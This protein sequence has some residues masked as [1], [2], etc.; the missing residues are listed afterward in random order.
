[1]ATAT[2]K[3]ISALR[4]TAARL[5]E[6]SNFQ[7]GHMGSC[8]C[9]HLA[10]TVTELSPAEIHRRAMERHGDWSQQS[11][12]HCPTS[13]LAIDHV[14]DEMLALGL[15]RSSAGGLN[16]RR[17][18]LLRELEL[19]VGELEADGFARANAEAMAPLR[20]QLK[21]SYAAA[22]PEVIEEARKENFFNPALPRLTL[23]EIAKEFLELAEAGLANTA[24]PG[25]GGVPVVD[26]RGLKLR[27][28][29]RQEGNK[30][31]I[32]PPEIE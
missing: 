28:Q 6:G 11:V 7:W 3:L 2:P 30:I 16:T 23:A 4:T 26:P 32:Q 24:S 22:P 9:G 31:E 18:R 5:R 10:Q 25:S 29:E 13:G 14:I 1:M 12:E 19:A 21:E 17:L 20:A 27:R 15:R 8:I